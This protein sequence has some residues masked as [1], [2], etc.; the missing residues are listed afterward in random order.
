MSSSEDLYRAG[1]VMAGDFGAS[2]GCVGSG[3]GCDEGDKEAKLQWTAIK[4][5]DGSEV[6]TVVGAPFCVSRWTAPVNAKSKALMKRSMIE[7]Y[8]EGERTRGSASRL[9][10]NCGLRLMISSLRRST[11]RPGQQQ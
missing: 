7:K 10:G 9:D 6:C 5:G 2:R 1:P 8:L 4:A 11:Q 3:K